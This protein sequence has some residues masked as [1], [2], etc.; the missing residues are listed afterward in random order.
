MSRYADPPLKIELYTHPLCGDECR[1]IA[2]LVRKD[3]LPRFWNSY[4]VEIPFNQEDFNYWPSGNP[5]G[6]EYYPSIAILKESKVKVIDG[7]NG[8]KASALRSILV[9]EFD[10]IEQSGPAPNISE[11]VDVGAGDKKSNWLLIVVLV[12]AALGI[13][14][15][16]TKK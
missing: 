10:M 3:V 1:R 11:N 6:F 2:N 8:I 4:L 16:V 15:Y 7:A 14:W 13:F 12:L 5:Y 9:N